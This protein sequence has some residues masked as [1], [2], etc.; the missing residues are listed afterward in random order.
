MIVV[1]LCR[2]IFRQTTPIEEARVAPLPTKLV[3]V[4]GIEASICAIKAL[5]VHMCG[6]DLIFIPPPKAAQ[7]A[8]NFFFISQRNKNAMFHF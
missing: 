4:D 3:K 5:A 6:I 7:T 8:R 1:Q 2:R